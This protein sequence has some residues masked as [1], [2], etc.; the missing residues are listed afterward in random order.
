MIKPAI[1][2]VEDNPDDL[3]LALI[4]F[5]E[6]A[7]PSTVFVARNGEQAL[8]F[9][10]RRERHSTRG[11][12]TDPCLVLMDL[13]LPRLNGLEVLQAMR[14]DPRTRFTPVVIMTSSREERDLLDSYRLGANSYVQKPVDFMQFTNAIRTL[15]CYWLELN[16][17]PPRLAAGH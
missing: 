5:K 6:V 12:E 15:G 3:E 10:F 14:A 9:L 13:N 16:A 17:S 8:D 1:L 4:A 7:V 11:S 2:L